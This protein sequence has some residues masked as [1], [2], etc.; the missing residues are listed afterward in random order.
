VYNDF[1]YTVVDTQGTNPRSG[2]TEP[3]WP[4]EDGAQVFEDA[5]GAADTPPSITETPDT[6]VIPSPGIYD[7][8]RNLFRR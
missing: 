6:S 5:D 4:T 8:Y 2:S 3:T 1:Y 7:R